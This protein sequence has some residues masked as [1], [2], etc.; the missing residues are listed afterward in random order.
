MTGS[1]RTSL[2]AVVKKFGNFVSDLQSRAGFM[3][4]DI[5]GFRFSAASRISLHCRHAILVMSGCPGSPSFPAG[6][7]DRELGICAEFGH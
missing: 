4:V 5:N 3:N 7:T 2:P 6:L 1:F